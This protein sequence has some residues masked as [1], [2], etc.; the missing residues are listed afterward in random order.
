M[1]AV[2]DREMVVRIEGEVEL[3]HPFGKDRDG[4]VSAKLVGVVRCDPT[5]RRPTSFVMAST[6]ARYV[7]QWQGKPQPERMGIGVELAEIP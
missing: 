7:W 4:K 5:S 2:D 3:A 6:E 1:A